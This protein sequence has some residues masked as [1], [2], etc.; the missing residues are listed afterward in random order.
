MKFPKRKSSIIMI[1]PYAKYRSLDSKKILT[2]QRNRKASDASCFFM[3]CRLL[4]CSCA[5]IVHVSDYQACAKG[6]ISKLNFMCLKGRLQMKNSC[7]TSTFVQSGT[8]S[9]RLPHLH[10]L[11]SSFVAPGTGFPMA[12]SIVILQSSSSFKINSNCRS[13]KHLGNHPKIPSR[14][15]ENAFTATNALTWYYFMNSR[16]LIE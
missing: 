7:R 15:R 5:I 1:T 10:R 6:E 12:V 8:S 4:W 14:L 2:H 11:T 9:S 3:C 13:S 16:L